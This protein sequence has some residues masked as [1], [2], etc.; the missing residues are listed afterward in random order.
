M[1]FKGIKLPIFDFRKIPHFFSMALN[2]IK[3]RLF[4]LREMGHLPN[5]E[6]N[7]LKL[8]VLRFRKIKRFPNTD[9][10]MLSLELEEGP[11]PIRLSRMVYGLASLIVLAIVWASVTSLEEVARA[12]GHIVPAGDVVAIQHFEGGL[13]EKIFVH[14]NDFVKAGTPLVRL[15]QASVYSELAQLVA[16]RDALRL[17]INRERAIQD[18]DIPEF[19]QTTDPDQQAEQKAYFVAKS[20]HNDARRATLQYRIEEIRARIEALSDQLDAARMAEKAY[21]ED[22]TTVRDLFSRKL[23][24]RERLVLARRARL[25]AAREVVRLSTQL[26]VT[27]RELASAQGEAAEFDAEIRS[28]ALETTST[29]TTQLAEVDALIAGVRDRLDRLTITAPV[30]GV[31]TEMTLRAVNAVVAPGDPI[32]RLVPTGRKLLVAARVRPSDIGRVIRGQP[33]S[34]RVG[35]YDHAKYGF[36]PGRVEE[37]SPTTAAS[38]DGQPYYKA[39]ISLEKEYFG[40]EEIGAR[41]LPGMTVEADIKNGTRTLLSYLLRPISRGWSMAFR[42]Q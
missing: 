22:E 38:E 30:D 7:G 29:L 11:P 41:L 32:M 1:Q 4:R 24:T 9:D 15:A 18:T 26:D 6:F 8:P 3:S 10:L 2:G 33:A 27:R 25:D 31:V 37:I 16:R 28:S 39:L 40:P 42:E 23:T 21:T 20:A 12:P 36:V 13:V 35:A 19:D 5:M 34:I 14:N 17:S